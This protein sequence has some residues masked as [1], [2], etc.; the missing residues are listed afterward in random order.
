MIYT[1]IQYEIN[2]STAIIKINQPDTMNK[3]DFTN[4]KEMIHALKESESNIECTSIILTSA[5]EYFCG[6]GNLGDFRTKTS[7]EIREF[8]DALKSIHCTITG[9]SKPVIAAV[10]GHAFGGG[11][12]LVEACDL[13]VANIDACFATPETKHG[14][15][16]AIA[17]VGS[18]QTL[19]KKIA[20][21]LALLGDVL[22][23]EEALEKGLVNFLCPKEE[24]LS[25]AIE[26]G[27]RISKNNPSAISLCKRLYLKTVDLSYDQQ[28][29][30]AIGMLVTMLKSE[31]ATIAYEANQEGRKPIWKNG[32]GG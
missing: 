14:L 15:G 30:Y 22:T 32:L 28:L 7:M 17:M 10:Q 19:P 16:P 2:G 31:D 12:S 25:K 29:E 6:G 8:G 18:I 20:M 3:L 21:Q 27:E 4:M 13:A 24:V 23:A 26:L 1:T 11:F 9:L 5:G